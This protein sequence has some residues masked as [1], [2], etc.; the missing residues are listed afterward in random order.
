VVHAGVDGCR[1]GWVVATSDGAIRVV[2]RFPDVLDLADGV[3]GV[4]MPVGLPDVGR[5]R[6]CDVE[7]RARLGP[8]RSSV[9]PAP[10]RDAL[11]ATSFADVRGLSLQAWHL[12]PKVREVDAVWTARVVE[13][14]PELVL[15]VLG[16]A[17]M[18]RPKRTAEGRAERLAV[19]G[20]SS[21]S[22]LPGAAP[23]DVIDALACLHGALRVAA[24]T[25]LVLGD[26]SLDARG[27]P[28]RIHA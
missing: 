21:V 12:V 6:A 18:A 25:A 9:F 7:A 22:R 24:G 14:H 13:V 8:R 26:A 23:D 15:A 3:V 28:M 2:P 10:T 11:A 4:D 1:G 16:G 5:R 19:L 27:R 20:L 17:P